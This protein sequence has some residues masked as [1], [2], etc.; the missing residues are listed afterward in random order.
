MRIIVLVL[1]LLVVTGVKQSLTKI[2]FESLQFYD[3]IFDKSDMGEGL[4]ARV[5]NY[6]FRMLEIFFLILFI[7]L[8]FFGLFE[9]K[10]STKT[11]SPKGEFDPGLVSTC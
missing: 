3:P 9:L 11:L 5:R 6:C 7:L 1:V 10:T 8:H 4:G 2:N